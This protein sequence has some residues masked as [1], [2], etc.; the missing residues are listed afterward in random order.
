MKARSGWCGE[1]G[2]RKGLKIPRW[3]HRTGSSPVTSIKYGVCISIPH[4]LI[5][6]NNGL[7]PKDFFEEKG[8]SEAFFRKNVRERLLWR[9]HSRRARKEFR[10]N[11]LSSP[12]TGFYRITESRLKPYKRALDQIQAQEKRKARHPNKVTDF[13]QFIEGV[14]RF[15]TAS[16]VL[17]N[18]N[19]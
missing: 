14:R 19:K 6:M 12:V 18:Y 10:R 9:S 16:A 4:I 13:S 3:Q 11:S 5:C 2:R 8:F 1:I 17:L 7:E 15:C